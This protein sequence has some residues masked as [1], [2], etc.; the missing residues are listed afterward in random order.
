MRFPGIGIL[1]TTRRLTQF[2]GVL[3]FTLPCGLLA[4]RATGTIRGVVRRGGESPADAVVGTPVA[5]DGTAFRTSTDSSGSFVLTRVPVASYTLVVTLS[6]GAVRR[7][8]TVSEGQ[9][10]DV[11]IVL[12]SAGTA[13]R[14]EDN[15][16]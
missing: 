4:Q 10:T 5:L 3:T 14:A 8:V 15:G 11:V 16:G 6:D 2:V 1:R 9:V 7:G 12:D 13:R